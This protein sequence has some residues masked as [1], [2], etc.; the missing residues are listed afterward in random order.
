MFT[1]E[2]RQDPALRVLVFVNTQFPWVGEATATLVTGVRLGLLMHCLM[3]LQMADLSE[4]L[5]ARLKGQNREE[6]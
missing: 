6:N 5:I 1:S 4:T 3:S 2:L